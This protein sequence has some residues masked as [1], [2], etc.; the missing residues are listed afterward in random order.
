MKPKERNQYTPAKKQEVLQKIE[1]LISSGSTVKEA[2]NKLGLA[3]G[4]FHKWKRAGVKAATTPP[5]PPASPT[6]SQ[7]KKSARFLNIEEKTKL[8]TEVNSLTG[9]GMSVKDALVK[10]GVS[11][12]NFYAYRRQIGK[13]NGNLPAVAGSGKDLQMM[14]FDLGAQTKAPMVLM[15]GNAEDF[16]S[17]LASLGNLL[18]GT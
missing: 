13:L 10:T 18:R 7:P 1:T 2:C 12:A 11:Q 3:D 15:I 5:S 16:K 4:L 9:S 14:Q 8:V 17:T 6:N